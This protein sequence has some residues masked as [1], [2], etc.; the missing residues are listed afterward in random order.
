MHALTLLSTVSALAS[1]VAAE[2]LAWLPPNVTPVHPPTNVSLNKRTLCVLGICLGG[3]S[4]SAYDSDVNNCGS[5]WNRCNDNWLF[6]GGRQC[7]NGVCAPQ[8]CNN[9][10]DFNWLTGK[11]QDVS[12]DR[13]NCGKCGQKCSVD[14]AT[15][16]K[17]V[18]GQCYA[19]SCAAGYSLASGYCNKIVD[20]TSDVNNCG[21]VGNK[22]SGFANGNGFTCKNS[23]CQPLSC[24]SGFDFDFAAGVC[25]DV[26]SDS[27]NCGRCGNQC[28]FP[29]GNGQCVNGQC[30]LKSCLNGYYNIDGTCTRI[31]TQTDPKNCGSKGNVCIYDN[32]NAGCKNGQCYLDSCKDGY[33]LKTTQFLFWGSTTCEKVDTSSDVN[34]CGA[35]NN[36][37][38]RSVRNGNTPSC[39]NGKCWADCDRG[40]VRPLAALVVSP[41]HQPDHFLP[42]Q[43]WDATTL[44]CKDT[45]SDT[46]NCGALNQKCTVPNGVAQCS[47]GNCV[48]K[49]CNDGYA[50]K[51]GSCVKV[52]TDNDKNNCGLVGTICPSTYRNGGV[53]ICL[54]GK[55][56]TLCD[57]DFDFDFAFGFCRDVSQDTQNCGRCG[58]KCNLTGATQTICKSGKC[59]ATVCQS[60]YTLKDGACTKADTTSDVNNCGAIGNQ[61]QFLPAGASGICKNSKCELTGCPTNYV[62][63][64]GV[65]VKSTASQRARLAKKDKVLSEKSLCPG[66]NEQACPILG[67]SSYAQAVE[68]HFNA[69]QE[70]SGV[71]LGSGGYECV[72]TTQALESCG[73]CAST[74]EGQDC[75]AIRGA[76]GV[77]CDAGICVVFSCEA[78]W[79]PSLKG[80][81]CVRVKGNKLHGNS[82]SS[83]SNARRHLAGRHQAHGSVSHL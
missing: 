83:T 71:M 74:G 16:T 64:N 9:L 18:S 42:S 55:C 80:D 5:R 59:Y 13:D 26:R 24:N 66:K 32:A 68:H 49:S 44:S 12:S 2:S 21:R 1:V 58:Q 36:A 41:A 50:L 35:M 31:D 82:T 67:S 23:V 8:Y 37:C 19:T 75:T 38:P 60:G 70:F 65:C 30:Q 34:N 62:L 7:V 22:C 69:A 15:G 43:S 78:G 48:A 54:N 56:Q 4:S 46:D 61:C 40:Y 25:R 73:G 77:G 27:S 11:C 76:A 79:K 45:S 14:N 3:S 29:Y 51:S 28:Q 53:G 17:C 57:N 47:N 72:D 63:K 20:T 39:K 6:G 52:D 33:Q 10:F 81:K